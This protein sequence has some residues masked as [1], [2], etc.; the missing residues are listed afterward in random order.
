VNALGDDLASVF[1]PEFDI[2]GF[3]PRG[4]GATTPLALCFQSDS[5]VAIWYLN[6][7]ASLNQSDNSVPLA[8]ARALVLGERCLHA[9]GGNGNEDIGGTVHEW[10]PG[11]FMDTGSV[12]TDMLRITEKLGQEKLQYFG[13]VSDK[14]LRHEQSLIEL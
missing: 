6:E 7:V 1:G 9:L 3:D 5:Q 8:R 12:A 4:V 11:R 10:G 2:L 13:A 14:S